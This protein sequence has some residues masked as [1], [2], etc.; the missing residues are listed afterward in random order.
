MGVEDLIRRSIGPHVEV[1]VN[2]A[3]DLPATKIDPNQ[4]ELALLNLAVNA[5]DAMSGGG[6]LRIEVSTRELAKAEVGD[7][8]AGAYVR[9]AVADFGTGRTRRPSRRA[10]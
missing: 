6:T 4:L 10:I 7:L 3:E 5:S 2:L 9:L 8:P 1:V